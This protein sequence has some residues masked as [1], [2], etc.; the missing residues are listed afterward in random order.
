MRGKSVISTVGKCVFQ[1]KFEGDV[2]KGEVV[3]LT[4][5]EVLTRRWDLNKAYF[6]ENDRAGDPCG[7]LE[8]RLVLDAVP[9]GADPGRSWRPSRSLDPGRLG[10]ADSVVAEPRR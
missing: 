3:T 9:A 8:V 2:R 6:G 7:G 4:Y 1:Q 10:E 5:H